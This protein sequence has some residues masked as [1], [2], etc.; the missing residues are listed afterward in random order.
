ARRNGERHER[1]IVDAVV[2]K[3]HH[4]KRSDQGD[5]DGH[6]WNQ[7]GA[8]ASQEDEN[9]QNNQGN[10]DH[11][12]ALDVANG[13]TNGEGTV[14]HN[15]RVNGGRNRSLQCR[16][17]G[18]DAVHGLDDV[19]AGLAENDDEDGGL[20]V[21]EAGSAYVFRGVPDA[22]DIGQLDGGAIV[23]PDHKRHVV[24][25]LQKLVVGG[26]IRGGCTIC[27]LAFGTV[28]ILP[29][30]HGGSFLQAET[31]VVELGRIHV[32]AHSRQRTTPHTHLP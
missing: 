15:F 13:S 3:V 5:G 21:D 16:K 18:T 27:E 25:R 17:C 10:R 9:Y 4:A 30:Q 26:D 24:H 11:E 29:T 20:A 19:G 32:H 28:G 14:E 31:I 8:D 2:T 22:R 7:C 23:V 12:A 1:E 6:S